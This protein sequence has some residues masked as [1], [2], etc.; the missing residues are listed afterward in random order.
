MEF[1]STQQMTPSPTTVTLPTAA[2]VH[3][4]REDVVLM[5][6]ASAIERDVELHPDTFENYSIQLDAHRTFVEVHGITADTELTA[7]RVATW[8]DIVLHATELHCPW[9]ELSEAGQQHAE[10]K[11]RLAIQHFPAGS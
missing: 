3:R 1:M 9:D 2:D 5:G 11:M 10:T 7:H 8:R 6:E 4:W